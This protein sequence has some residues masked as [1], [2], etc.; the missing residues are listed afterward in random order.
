MRIQSALDRKTYSLWPD[1]YTVGLKL[2]DS[3]AH[4]ALFDWASNSA[5]PRHLKPEKQRR[6]RPTPPSPAQLPKRVRRLFIWGFI[7][8]NA[9]ISIAWACAADEAAEA[10]LRA[11]FLRAPGGL[12]YMGENFAL[13]AHGL[14]LGRWWTLLT[15]SIS[16]AEPGH[17]IVNMCE[18][19]T[20][21]SRC[22]DLGVGPGSIAGL[23]LGSAVCSGVAGVANDVA[24]WPTRHM[25]ASGVVSGLSES[26]FFSLFR[27]RILSLR[28]S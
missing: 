10:G 26:F 22:F 27:L 4:A 11:A 25:G 8:T 9:A 18:F 23:M 5:Q 28:G 7:S 1:I 2:A 21:A 14:G 6:S 3:C 19:Y 20:W 15:C 16:H 13:S 24:W 17:L 12:A